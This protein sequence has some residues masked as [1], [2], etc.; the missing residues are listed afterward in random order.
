MG[1]DLGPGGQKK[2]KLGHLVPRLP[3]NS[4]QQP[5]QDVG[6]VSTQVTKLP[7]QFLFLLRDLRER[8]SL[9]NVEEE[10]ELGAGGLD[11]PSLLLRVEPGE[12]LCVLLDLLVVW[13][14][15]GVGASLKLHGE[16]GTRFRVGISPRAA[17]GVKQVVIAFRDAPEI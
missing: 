9:L 14:H 1:A 7:Q 2:V 10:G 17:E 15:N 13:E 16:V 8:V 5:G 3:L 6:H 11:L 12:E 4:I